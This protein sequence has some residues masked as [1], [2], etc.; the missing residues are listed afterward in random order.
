MQ[1]NLYKRPGLDRKFVYHLEYRVK[2][3][4]KLC[5]INVNFLTWEQNKNKNFIDSSLNVY[6]FLCI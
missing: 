3:N 1:L 4:V 2:T 5:L 6:S